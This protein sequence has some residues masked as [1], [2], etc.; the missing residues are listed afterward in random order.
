MKFFL[1]IDLGTSY[2]KTGIFDVDGSLK[3]LGR[4]PV[5]KETGDGSVCELP[6]AVFWQTLNDCVGEA[7]K[8]AGIIPEEIEAVSYSSQANSFILLD[9]KDEPLTPLILWTDSRAKEMDFSFSNFFDD[10][11]F[12]KKTGLGIRLNFESAVAKINWFREKQPNVWKKVSSI[13]TIADYLT[14]GLT[15]QKVSDMST[16]SLT[17]LL[18]IPK[19][20]LWDDALKK[21]K[22]NR[23][24]FPV[25]KRMGSYVGK[26]NEK[27]TS[28]IGLS[29]KNSYYLG[30]LD[31]HCAAVGSGVVQTNN[32]SE[33]TGTVL[34]CVGSFS[35]YNP[36]EKYCTAPG[37]FKDQYFQM[38]FNS[39]GALSLEWYQKNFASEH[40]IV[41]LLAMAEKIAMGCEGL[42][43]RP[44]AN[45]YPGLEA[46]NNIKSVHGYGHFVRALLES[47]SESLVTLVNTIKGNNFS[48]KVISTGGGAQSDLWIKIKADRLNTVFYIPECTETAC[49]GAAMIGAYGNSQNS[50]WYKFVKRWIRYNKVI[51]PN[52]R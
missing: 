12:L 16:L 32:V 51:I 39:N 35:K 24:L 9:E 23:D 34:S 37:L 21:M 45:N 3:G 52:K 13:L 40:S 7:V 33:S 2:F 41:E 29:T 18:D 19:L 10:E 6:A 22:L 36:G 25:P 14:F 49:M 42:S 47:T 8:K 44:C 1:G 20:K 31:H 26:I 17:G 38:A 46:F 27:G 48:D 4:Q 28:L 43:A 50:D 30:G 11:E 15:G 5:K